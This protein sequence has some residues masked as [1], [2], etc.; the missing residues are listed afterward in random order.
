MKT[1]LFSIYDSKA[2]S[3]LTPFHQLNEALAIRA[4]TECVNDPT[5]PLSKNLGD[6]TL[7]ELGEFDD[8]TGSHTDL[9]SIVNHGCLITFR[10][11]NQLI[12]NPS[13]EEIDE[14]GSLD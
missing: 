2:K 8:Q 10:E 14:L 1:K 12:E 4:V 5:H 11:P 13:E 3:Y 7:F 9:S 6:Y